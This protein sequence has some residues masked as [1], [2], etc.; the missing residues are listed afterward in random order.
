LD[1]P[2]EHP[3]IAK[4]LEVVPLP[5]M[6][7]LSERLAS[8]RTVDGEW[9]W[10]PALGLPNRSPIPEWRMAKA[11]ETAALV[12]LAEWVEVRLRPPAI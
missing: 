5:L 11:D 9:H 1:F 8:C 7:E 6:A 2:D 12:R 4:A 10:P 3:T